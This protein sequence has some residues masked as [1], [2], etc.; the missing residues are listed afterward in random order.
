M[1]GTSEP[2]PAVSP[3]GIDPDQV[4]ATVNGTEVVGADL[5]TSISQIIATAEA[6]GIDVTDPGVQADIRNQA[7]NMLVNTALL[8]E[9]AAARGIAVTDAEVEARIDSLVEEVGSED[10]LLSRMENLGITEETL[11]ED[12]RSELTIQALLDDVFADADVTVTDEEVNALYETSVAGDPTAPALEEVRDQVEA[13]VQASKEQTVV[14]ELINEL[15]A[16][17]EVVIVE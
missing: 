1:R 17:A 14:N 6:Q 3:V 16:D 11:R 9:E 12:V 7:V 4:V 15:R 2:A 8:E 13:Q 5:T 10:L